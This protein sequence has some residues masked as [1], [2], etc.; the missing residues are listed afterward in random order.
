[1]AWP[2]PGGPNDANLINGTQVALPRAGTLSGLYF[3]SWNFQSGS[4]PLV[5]TLM[6]N[7]SPTALTLTVPTSAGV[8]TWSDTIHSVSVNA[9]DKVSI[10]YDST[11]TGAG[12]S[13]PGTISLRYS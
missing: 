3:H 1:V 9:G 2:W 4:G 10:K 7:G 8:G 13:A 6:V 12:M 5:L 11:A